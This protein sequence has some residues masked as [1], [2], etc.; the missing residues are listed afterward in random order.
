MR[1]GQDDSAGLRPGGSDRLPPV[2]SP[3]AAAGLRRLMSRLREWAN[4]SCRSHFLRKQW[5]QVG[6][7]A[8]SPRRRG[9]RALVPV[10]QIVACRFGH[11]SAR[12]RAFPRDRFPNPP[13]IPPSPWPTPDASARD[14]LLRPIG[15]GGVGGQMGQLAGSR[16]SDVRGLH[17]GIGSLG[18]A[19][20]TA[21]VSRGPKIEGNHSDLKLGV[22][23]Q[24]SSGRFA[25]GACAGADTVPRPPVT[26]RIGLAERAYPTQRGLR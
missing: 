10:S 19:M 13:S 11:H 16:V 2:A 23:R 26:A 1:P 6:P 15:A 12:T 22:G 14:R 18:F 7:A 21:A 20:V 25:A 5:G 4:T 3:T 9:L 24:P 8:N 17:P